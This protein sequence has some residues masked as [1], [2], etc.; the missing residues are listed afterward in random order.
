MKESVANQK[1]EIVDLYSKCAELESVKLQLVGLS[2]KV[3]ARD[4]EG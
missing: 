2:E 4:V 1:T 3:V